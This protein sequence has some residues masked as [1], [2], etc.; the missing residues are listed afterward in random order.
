MCIRD[1]ST[2]NVYGSVGATS[3]N[4]V[5]GDSVQH[6]YHKCGNSVFPGRESGYAHPQD[7]QACCSS[8][9]FVG[10]YVADICRFSWCYQLPVFNPYTVGRQTRHLAATLCM[11]A[12]WS[13]EY[14]IFGIFCQKKRRR[15]GDPIL[16]DGEE[17]PKIDENGVSSLASKSASMLGVAYTQARTETQ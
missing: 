16:K 12:N 2:P 6:I 4:A 5:A 17:C 3:S 8:V 1:R 7:H 10:D 9:C 14:I 15:A 11:S 13:K